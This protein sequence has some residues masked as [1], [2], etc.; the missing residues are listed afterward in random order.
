ML[1]GCFHRVPGPD[2][3]RPST[4]PRAGSQELRRDATDRLA[5][6]TAQCV[7]D[8]AAPDSAIDCSQVVARVPGVR[9]DATA[10]QVAVGIPS[11]SLRTGFSAAQLALRRLLQGQLA[12]R[13]S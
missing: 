2:S 5:R 9:I 4:R 11:A 12:K 6:P 13:P 1:A 8:K 3:A 7:I 10:G